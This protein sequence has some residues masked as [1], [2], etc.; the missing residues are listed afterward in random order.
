MIVKTRMRR[1]LNEFLT[2]EIRLHTRL[3]EVIL[4]MTTTLDLR[5]KARFNLFG[6]NVYRG[7]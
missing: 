5:L 7:C 2:N 6:I 1:R 4:G 3:H